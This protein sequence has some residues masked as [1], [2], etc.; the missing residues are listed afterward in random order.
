MIPFKCDVHLCYYPEKQRVKM[1]KDDFQEKILALLYFLQLS[2]C[3]VK[4]NKGFSVISACKL[5][6]IRGGVYEQLQCLAE[7]TQ[8]WL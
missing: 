3:I 2:L 8:L 1:R 7:Q 5:V 4:W 6:D